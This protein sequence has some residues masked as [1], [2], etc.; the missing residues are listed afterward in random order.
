[1]Y[2]YIYILNVYMAN[3]PRFRHKYIDGLPLEID[4]HRHFH[5]SPQNSELVHLL[6]FW[7]NKCF[8]HTKRF[9]NMYI[10]IYIYVYL[11]YIFLKSSIHIYTVIYTYIYIYIYILIYLFYSYMYIYILLISIYIVLLYMYFRRT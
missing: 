2:I 1:M 3:Y 6:C 11:K 9:F 10:Y 8:V 5:I 4:T 7:K